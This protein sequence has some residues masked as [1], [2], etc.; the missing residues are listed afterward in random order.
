MGKK[1]GVLTQVLGEQPKAVTVHCQGHS[2][3]LSVKTM[4]K[5][6]AILLEKFA[7]S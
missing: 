1:S 3:S 7:Y 5:N 4:T 2:L 6:L